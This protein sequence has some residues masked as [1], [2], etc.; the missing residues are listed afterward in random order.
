[1]SCQEEIVSWSELYC[2]GGGVSG[3]RALKSQNPHPQSFPLWSVPLRSVLPQIQL[4]ALAWKKVIKF[5]CINRSIT[6]CSIVRRSQWTK[7]LTVKTHVVEKVSSALFLL[8]ALRPVKAISHQRETTQVTQCHRGVVMIPCHVSLS[9]LWCNSR[10]VACPVRWPFV[11]VWPG[12]HICF[13]ACYAGGVLGQ[14]LAG[15]SPR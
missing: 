3:V 11:L 7:L 10:S 15:R 1:M 8:P 13:R 2:E 4:K 9:L 5:L 12:D 14:F 6:K